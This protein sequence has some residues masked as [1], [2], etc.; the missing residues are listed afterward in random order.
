[1]KDAAVQEFETGSAVHGALDGFQ[2]IDSS[3]DRAGR[4]GCLQRRPHGRQILSESG[5]EA[6]QRCPDS[7]R[8]PIVEG[9]HPLLAHQRSEAVHEITHV[10]ERRDI[11][12]Q[13]VPEPLISL[14]QILPIG[15]QKA[16]HAPNGR[17]LP[18]VR[19]RGSGVQRIRGC[20]ALNCGPRPH[21]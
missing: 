12:Q 11:G 6:L 2:S 5:R 10:A 7:G 16:R 1:M 14:R 13:H 19:F 20:S 8:Q 4:P 9:A 15:L 17:R 21:R 18:C 3:L